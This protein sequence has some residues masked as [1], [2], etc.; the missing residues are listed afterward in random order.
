ME[1]MRETYSTIYLESNVSLR[2]NSGM[3]LRE[4]YVHIHTA[5]NNICPGP[6]Q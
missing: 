1:K 5:M 6:Q 4:K 2:V 3:M